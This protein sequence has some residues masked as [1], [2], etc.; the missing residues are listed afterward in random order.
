MKRK[1]SCEWYPASSGV[2]TIDYIT[3]RIV[4][5]T[6]TA[7]NFEGLLKCLHVS[8]SHQLFD[9][10]YSTKTGNWFV[11]EYGSQCCDQQSMWWVGARS[12]FLWSLSW[13]QHLILR[14]L[15]HSFDHIKFSKRTEK[16]LIFHSYLWPHCIWSMVH[17]ALLYEH[18]T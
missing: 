8:V 14:L 17:R 3:K 7:L 1:E 18:Q 5:S 12:T 11:H 15:L 2:E 10:W 6:Y 4:H 16:Y 9:I 13:E